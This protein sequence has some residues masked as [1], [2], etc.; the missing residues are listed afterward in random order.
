[1]VIKSFFLIIAFLI[2]MSFWRYRKIIYQNYL[3]EIYPTK[4][5]ATLLSA[6]NNVEQAN[7]LWL[8]MAIAFVV[9]KTNLTTGLGLIGLGTLV[10]IPFFISSSLAVLKSK[11]TSS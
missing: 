2:N 8:P 5:K 6:M 9:S 11:S 4:Y 7:S 10:F 3:L 1:M